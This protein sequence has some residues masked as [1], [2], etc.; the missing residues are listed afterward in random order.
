MKSLNS[1]D[2][3][4]VVVDDSST[5][6]RAVKLAFESM[7]W[8]VEALDNSVGVA[9]KIMAMRPDVLLIDLNM[10]NLMGE[11]LVRI[12][13]NKNCI[14]NSRLYLFSS[15][16]ALEL[17]RM[18][19]ELGVEGYLTKDT[20]YDEMDRIVRRDLKLASLKL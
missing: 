15:K 1:E 3:S 6:R 14:P 5:V 4:L 16:D 8:T 20:A 13:K 11:S 19:Q 9:L 7:G 17:A 10:P 18:V 12:L 2:L